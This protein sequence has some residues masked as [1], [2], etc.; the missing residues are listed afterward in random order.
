MCKG[1]KPVANVIPPRKP[2]KVPIPTGERPRVEGFKFNRQQ[3]Q[4][5]DMVNRLVKGT[6]SRPP[7]PPELLNLVK[8]QL[9]VMML[10][11]FIED[12][13]TFK[14]EEIEPKTYKIQFPEVLKHLFP[15]I[16]WRDLDQ[17]FEANIAYKVGTLTYN[18]DM[19]VSKLEAMGLTS[20]NYHGQAGVGVNDV[21]VHNDRFVRMGRTFGK[22]F[23]STTMIE[24]HHMG[25]TGEN[26]YDA[27]VVVAIFVSS[28][29]PKD[30]YVLAQQ[31]A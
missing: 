24:I 5:F 31:R 11:S 29:Y 8:E 9:K 10:S 1:G 4:I 18:Y 30:I 27:A 15:T 22:N 7:L 3:K 26:P 6:G 12:F 16:S 13:E 19:L 20:G 2:S 28:K 14:V 21:S 17:S 23:G 25:L